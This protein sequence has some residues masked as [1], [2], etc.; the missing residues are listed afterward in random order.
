[1]HAQKCFAVCFNV[2]LKNMGQIPYFQTILYAM[3]NKVQN[4]TVKGKSIDS[5]LGIRTRDCRIVGAHKSTVLWR[6]PIY[7]NVKFYFKDMYKLAKM[8]F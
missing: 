8:P 3:T 2:F 4:W 7:Y 5:V 1:M 6:P